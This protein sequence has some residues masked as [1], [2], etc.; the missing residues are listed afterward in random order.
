M[1]NFGIRQ[2]ASGYHVAYRSNQQNNCPGCGQSHWIVGRQA[3]ECAFCATA[4]P[5]SEGSAHGI[6]TIRRAE[7][8][9][10]LAA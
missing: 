8:A 10:S 6:G 5:I 4:I 7:I 1:F 3:A 2:A 9:A